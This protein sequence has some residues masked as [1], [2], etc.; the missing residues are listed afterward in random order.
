MVTHS[1]FILYYISTCLVI[2]LFSSIR[3]LTIIFAVISEELNML[4]KHNEGE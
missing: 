2:S 3:L 1:L 4:Q